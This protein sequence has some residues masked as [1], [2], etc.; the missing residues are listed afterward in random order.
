MAT[1]VVQANASN[2][3]W[4]TVNIVAAVAPKGGKQHNQI[5]LAQNTLKQ[6]KTYQPTASPVPGLPTI[7]ISGYSGPA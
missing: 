3:Q 2:K 5:P 1:V 7:Y 4:K 6:F